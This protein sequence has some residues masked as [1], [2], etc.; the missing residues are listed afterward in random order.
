SYLPVS[1]LLFTVISARA[2]R[3]LS[4]Q[5][6]QGMGL[7]GGK[8]VFTVELRTQGK[9]TETLTLYPAVQEGIPAR[10]SG[11]KSVLLLP[12]GT[13]GEIQKKVKDV[14]EA[15]KVEASE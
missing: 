8:P 12:P 14:R 11:R 1:D 7:S 5:E 4:P 15:K 2:D 3:V 9:G 13:L 10:A 6:A